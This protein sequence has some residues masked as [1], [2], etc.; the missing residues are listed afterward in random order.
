MA[1]INKAK[2]EANR[3]IMKELKRRNMPYENMKKA[4]QDLAAVLGVSISHLPEIAARVAVLANLTGQKFS[5]IVGRDKKV[6]R[7]LAAK[8]LGRWDRKQAAGVHPHPLPSSGPSETDIREFYASW[9]WKR[10]SYDAKLKRGRK[11]ECCGA[12]APRV[13]IHTDHV[14]PIRKYWHL[15]LDPM[16]LQ[17]LCEDCNMGKGSR[18]ETDFRLLNAVD[19]A[20]YEPELTADEEIRLE[21]ICNQLRIN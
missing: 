14:K 1:K 9:E 6:Q 3:A 13:V 15:R 10:L 19:D 8:R 21:A 17:V 20:P 18:D 11:C 4:T 2:I 7:S 12:Q 16:N 5:E